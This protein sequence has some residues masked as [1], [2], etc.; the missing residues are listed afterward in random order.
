MI[1]FWTNRVKIGK[2]T[3]EDVPQIYRDAVRE[4]LS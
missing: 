3:I 1:K 4:A 2:C